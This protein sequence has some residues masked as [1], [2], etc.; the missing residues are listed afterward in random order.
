[1]TTSALLSVCILAGI[2]GRREVCLP[3][4]S[5][6]MGKINLSSVVGLGNADPRRGDEAFRV[7]E[8]EQS[9]PDSP[10]PGDV[11]SSLSLDAR[12]R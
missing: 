9:R 10:S 12:S 5:E 7:D 2:A 4:S 3:V 8:S 6:I 1:M 11:P